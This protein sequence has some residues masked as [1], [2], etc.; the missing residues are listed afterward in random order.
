MNKGYEVRSG[1][2]GAR[3]LE[4]FDAT[5]LIGLKVVVKNAAFCLTDEDGDESVVV[6]ML[7]KLAASA[8]VTRCL[9]EYRLQPKEIKAMRKILGYSL[10]EMA[11]RMDSKTA[12]ATFSR[13]EQGQQPMG[14]YAEKVLRLL[15]C[16]ELREKAAGVSYDG[17]M[18][19]RLVIIDPAIIGE[20]TWEV[21]A[22]EFSLVKVKHDGDLTDSW[23]APRMA[24]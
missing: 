23:S 13:W 24:A 5:A 8:A 18:I 14:G 3:T 20:T 21:P 15:I 10:A 7:D 4:S 6:P 16:E 17:R 9:M 22:M 11:S 12:A 1:A 2:S 19:S